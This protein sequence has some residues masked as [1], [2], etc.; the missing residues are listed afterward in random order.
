MRRVLLRQQEKQPSKEGSKEEMKA[1]EPIT[2]QSL[3][4]KP[5]Q[6]FPFLARLLKDKNPKEFELPLEL[7][8]F[9]VFPGKIV[10]TSVLSTALV[11]DPCIE[12]RHFSV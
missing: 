3:V 12:K 11:F 10:F 8:D 1:Q 4:N 9:T 2:S 7:Q 5:E 6:V